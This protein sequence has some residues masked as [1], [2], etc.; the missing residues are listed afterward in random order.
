MNG[1]RDADGAGDQ[2]GGRSFGGCS[3][4]GRGFGGVRRGA[5][6]SSQ[7]CPRWNLARPNRWNVAISC[8][9]SS[10]DIRYQQR[11]AGIWLQRG[12]GECRPSSPPVPPPTPRSAATPL[13]REAYRLCPACRGRGSKSGRYADCPRPLLIPAC[14][15]PLPP[16]LP[17]LPP[18]LPS[19]PPLYDPSLISPSGSPDPA[20][21]HSPLRIPIMAVTCR[22]PSLRCHRPLPC[23][24]GATR[25][26]RAPPRRR[27]PPR[28]LPQSR[29]PPS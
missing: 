3:L 19:R 21:L 1:R 25:A 10:T 18:R 26:A 13:P 11:M 16:R 9:L 7:P 22:S 6:Q 2:V 20:A 4:H 5:G 15:P 12:A 8:C 17:P 27:R 14:L 24:P 28:W 23:R 29:P